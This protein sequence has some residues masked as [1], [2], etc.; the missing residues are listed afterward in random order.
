VSDDRL[1]NIFFAIVVLAVA[2]LLVFLAIR[3]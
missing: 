3:S 2:L 1:E